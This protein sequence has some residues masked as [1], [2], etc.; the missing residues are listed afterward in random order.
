MGAGIPTTRGD[1]K[2]AEIFEVDDQ[3]E[4][5]K[6]GNSVPCMFN[7]FE[8]TVTKSNS[9]KEPDATNSKNAPKAEF[10]KGG[11]QT[12]QLSLFFDT[13]E[14]DTDVRD[15]TNKLW[16]FMAVKAKPNKRPHQKDSPPLV[17]F[18]WGP[19]YFVAYITNMTQKFIL[20]TRD[21]KPVRAKV[22]VTFTQYVDEKDE[23][24]QNPTSGEGPINRI[25]RVTG[26]DRLDL[27]AANVYGDATKWRAIA[28][29]NQLTDPL[30]LRPGQL[31][32]IPLE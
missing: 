11:A 6:G 17:A 31:L 30:A 28:E 9:F 32:R 10:S 1:L 13:Y 21:G 14:T 20:F 16:D 29:R 22:D 27:I 24:P 19:F 23:P 4:R 25:W 18:A 15:E 2:R 8:Y 7:P 26:G 12:L 3:R 5:V